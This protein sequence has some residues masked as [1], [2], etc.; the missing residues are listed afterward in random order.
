MRACLLVVS[1]FFSMSNCSAE[2]PKSSPLKQIDRA[3]LEK[4][5]S[6]TA[7]E[8]MIPGAVVLLHT[9][10]GA[11]KINYGSTKLGAATAPNALTHFRIASNTKTMTAALIM[12]LA[13]E[14]KLKLD[15]LISKYVSGVPD[16][17]KITI[18]N[19][20]EM[21]TGLYNYTSAPEVAESI[22]HHPTK[23]WT[24]KELLAIVCKHPTTAPDKTFHW[25]YNYNNTN[26]FLLGLVVEKVGGMPLRQAMQERLFKPLHLSDTQLPEASSNK[27]PEIYSHGYLYGSSSVA[28]AGIPPYSAKFKA[29]AKAGKILPK[30]Y[31]DVNHSFAAAAGGATST[32][33]DCATWISAL[34]TGSVLNPEYQRLWLNSLR[35]EDPSNAAG[36]E[37]G[38]G[39]SRLHW[40]KNAFLFHGG[41]TVGYNSFIG[42]DPANKVTLI[43]W[44]NLT[45]SLD[46]LPTANTLML[47]VLDH[48]YVESPIPSAKH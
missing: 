47:K 14:K 10:Q 22:D 28:L 12:L 19:L 27:I 26:Y 4:V 40:A 29:D 43:V 44:T 18:A 48:I 2:S 1:A 11:F 5:I 31:S 9:P 39:I 24:D 32:A 23:V 35:L 21:R 41:E 6:A 3:A 8:M 30:D 20:L 13:Q 25:K 45:V 33:A 15:D 36:M 7:K 34:C 46:E 42:F 38:Y 17:D 37:Y 16:G